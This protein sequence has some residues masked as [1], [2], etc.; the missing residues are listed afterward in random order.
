[1]VCTHGQTLQTFEVWS[2]LVALRA[3]DRYLVVNPF[4]HTFGYKAGII[5]GVM[6]GATLLPHAV[7]DA[8]Q[9]LHRIA[10]DRI[11]MLPG[12]PALFQSILAHPDRQ[13]RDLSSL[14][15][16]VTGA[17][18]I[19]VSLIER[20]RDDLGFDVVLTAYGLTEATGVVTMCREGDDATTIATTSGRAIPDVEVRVVDNR[21]RR[22]GL[23]ANAVR[24]SSVATT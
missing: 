1:V 16:A 14:R 10:D 2:R 17:A 13:G 12:P 9:V 18:T 19:P 11:N 24:W 21:W 15:L 22:G 7:F 23:A 8:T 5:A 4:F 6:R 3:G 20:M